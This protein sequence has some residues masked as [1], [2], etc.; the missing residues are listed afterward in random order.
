MALVQ[1]TQKELK[2]LSNQLN[3]LHLIIITQQNW[4]SRCHVSSN[5]NVDTSESGPEAIKKK[6]DDN[7]SLKN[8]QTLRMNYLGLSSLDIDNIDKTS[9]KKYAI[10]YNNMDGHWT[11]PIVYFTLHFSIYSNVVRYWHRNKVFFSLASNMSFVIIAPNSR[12][13]S[14]WLSI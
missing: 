7:I 5:F 11:S 10:D 4:S 1:S 12:T 13:L 2:S 14:V 9:N 8:L 3:F 6:T